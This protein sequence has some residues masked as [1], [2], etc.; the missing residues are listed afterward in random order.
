LDI[1]ELLLRDGADKCS[2]NGE[3]ACRI[4]TPNQQMI[5]PREPN[6]WGKDQPET[7]RERTIA[8]WFAG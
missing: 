1:S 8:G 3:Q 7:R 5:Q 2:L 6:A 4:I